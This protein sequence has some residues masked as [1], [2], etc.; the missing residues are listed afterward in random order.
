VIA[1][2]LSVLANLHAR[3]FSESWDEKALKNLIA[4][5]GAA[6]LIADPNL[7]F[8]LIRTA[9]DEAE[10]LTICVADAARRAGLGAALLQASARKATEVGAK[11]MFLEVT[12]DNEAAKSL[13]K[14]CGFFTVGERKSYYQGKDALV[15]RAGLPLALADA[16]KTL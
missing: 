7:G 16:G 4:S 1:A 8:V 3:S 2:D 9:A 5:P 10:V 12:A 15:M 14:R 11:A 13:Y 6:A